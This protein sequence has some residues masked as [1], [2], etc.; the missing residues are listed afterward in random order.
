MEL[1]GA[2]AV[3][4]G[5]SSGIGEATALA[6]ARRG[7]K[8]VLA[9]R[10]IERLEELAEGIRSRGGVALPASC[11]VTK[12]TDVKRLAA[13][14]GEA[15]G[16]CDA[17]V[18]NAGIR[19]G[20]RFADLSMEQI[21]RVVRVNE[22]GVMFTTKAFLPMLIARRRGHVVNIASLAGRFA[23]PGSSIYAATK[24][25]VV[26]FSESLYYELAPHGVLVTAVN[27]GFVATEGFPQ[28]RMD[29]RLVMRPERVAD[30]IVDVLRTG[31]APEVSI[32][33]WVGAAQAFRVLTPGP[34][35]WGVRKVSEWGIG[36]T[37]A[38]D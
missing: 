33:R 7:A 13:A 21:E 17:L 11:D 25:A 24:H 12:R 2:V 22:L 20:G 28:D 26:A 23:T 35:R 5:A 6:L 16:R 31:K 18:N 9:A 8:V 10:R 30:A 36:E 34:Y 3:V 38:T 19:G 1:S 15:F 27:P 32:P 37:R 14:V 29:P 4:T